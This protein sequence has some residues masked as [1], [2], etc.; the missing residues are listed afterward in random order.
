MAR[1]TPALGAGSGVGDATHRVS[2]RHTDAR[3]EKQEQRSP[4]TSTASGGQAIHVSDDQRQRAAGGS[5]ACESSIADCRAEIVFEAKWTLRWSQ[6]SIDGLLWEEAR[7]VARARSLCDGS[8]WARLTDAS[9]W[10]FSQSNQ[11][12][13]RRTCK[14]P[15]FFFLELCLVHCIAS[16]CRLGRMDETARGFSLVC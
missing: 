3:A 15:E 2:P 4:A 11:S 13:D 6:L 5:T 14:A 10:L 1:P 8:G 12:I 9:A 7:A 16:H